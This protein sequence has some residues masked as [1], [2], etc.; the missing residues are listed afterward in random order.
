M[1]DE[2]RHTI[3]DRSAKNL[4][5]VGTVLRQRKSMYPPYPVPIY[6]VMIIGTSYANHDCGQECVCM[7]EDVI[8]DFT[9]C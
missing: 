6:H 3:R 5:D 1:T 2:E 9:V 4:A 7:E 8:P